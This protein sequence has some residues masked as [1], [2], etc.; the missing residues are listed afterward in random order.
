MTVKAPPAPNPTYPNALSTVSLSLGVFTCIP[1]NGAAVNNTAY[2]DWVNNGAPIEVPSGWIWIG[3]ASPPGGLTGSWLGG[4][5]DISYL[6]QDISS[7]TILAWSNW[8][9]YANPVG[10]NDDVAPFNWQ[11]NYVLV[12][13]GDDVR[14]TMACAGPYAPDN[15]PVS[16]QGLAVLQTLL[17]Q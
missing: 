15:V 13:T 1:Q 8:D 5:A 4:M 11:P 6:L 7:G 14:F 10:I 9:H 12:N 16:A 17:P 2:T 3:V